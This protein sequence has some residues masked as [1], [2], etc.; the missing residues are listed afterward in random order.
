M[1][2]LKMDVEPCQVLHGENG[3]SEKIKEL[4][5]LTDIN[6]P[7]V[8]NASIL[9]LHIYDAQLSPRNGLSFVSE[10]VT[11]GSAYLRGPSNIDVETEAMASRNS[12]ARQKVD[13]SAPGKGKKERKLINLTPAGQMI[14][15]MPPFLLKKYL[16][17][18][19]PSIT[20]GASNAIVKSINLS[21]TTDNEIAYG[22]AVQSWQ[23]QEEG[24]YSKYIIQQKMDLNIIPSTIDLQIMGCPFLK[25]CGHIY[26]DAGTNTD[27]DNVYSIV[28]FTHSISPG[29]FVT[30]VK[31]A[32][33]F[34]AS[35]SNL[36][37]SLAETLTV[38]GKFEFE[39]VEKK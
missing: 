35:T 5:S 26:V 30:S 37:S 38:A 22:K 6:A 33:P 2:H 31:L 20:Y 14:V 24:V 27:M 9:R 25:V 4:T 18:E 1:V 19:Y 39:E 36:R 17:R 29:N 28:S 7:Y 23:D 13:N 12:S 32:L 16:K 3:R 21:S 15:N 34:A 11:N 10:H 8:S